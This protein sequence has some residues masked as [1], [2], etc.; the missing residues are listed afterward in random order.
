MD[1]VKIEEPC[2]ENKQSAVASSFSVSEGSGSVTLRPPEICSSTATSLS[3]RRTIGP[4][5][6][7]KRVGLQRRM[8]H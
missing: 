7:A 8:I 6:R 4:I 1:E 5:R 3:H 2:L